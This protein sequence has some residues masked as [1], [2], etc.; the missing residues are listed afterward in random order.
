LWVF[1]RPYQLL[2]ALEFLEI[3]DGVGAREDVVDVVGAEV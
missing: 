3:D 1:A 2:R